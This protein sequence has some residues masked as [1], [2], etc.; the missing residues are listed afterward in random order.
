MP[1]FLIV[2]LEIVQEIQDQ[3]YLST[4]YKRFVQKKYSC[5]IAIVFSTPKCPTI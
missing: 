2:D 4:S 5:N 1:K 3:M